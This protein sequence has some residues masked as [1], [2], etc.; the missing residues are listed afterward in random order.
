MAAVRKTVTIVFSDVVGSTPLG[1]RLDPESLRELTT[2]YYRQMA[3]VLQRHGGRVSKFIGDAAMAVFGVPRTHEDDALRAVRAASELAPAL[4]E[5]NHELEAAWGMRLLLRTGVNT[6][7]VVVGD[8]L[9]GQDVT[10]G[11][12]VNLAARLEQAA[13]PGQVV[14][15]ES[16]YRLVRDAVEVEPLPPL[17][18]KGKAEPVSAWTLLAVHP[19][20]PGHARRADAPMVGREAELAR[21]TRAFERSVAGR[22]CCLFTLLGTAGVGKSRLAAEFLASVEGRATVLRGCCLS[23][24][25]GITFWPLAEVLRQAARIAPGDSPAA[26]QAKLAALVGGEERAERIAGLLGRVLGLAGEAG[27]LEETFWAVRRLLEVGAA[28]RPLVVLLDDLHW[29][30]PTMLDLVEH[31][32]GLSRDRPVVLLC[33]GRPELVEQRPGWGG[34][35]ADAELL[36]LEP[37]REEDGLLLL[38]GLL[39]PSE[40]DEAARRRVVRSADGNPLFVEELVLMLV[41]EGHLRREHDRWVPA[42]DLSVLKVPLAVSGVILA[43]L[44]RLERMERAVVDRAAVVGREFT[45]TQVTELAP[46]PPREE[47]GARLE[48]LA[49]KALVRPEP[50]AAAATFGFRHQLLRDVAYEATSKRLRAEL[51]ERLAVWLEAAASDRLPEIQEVLGYHLEQAYRCLAALGAPGERGRLLAGRAG[52]HLGAAGRRAVA[53]EDMPAAVRLLERAA[54]LLPAEDPERLALL[55]DLAEALGAT[56]ELARAEALL[57]EGLELARAAQDERLVA[58][59]GLQRWRWRLFTGP[60]APAETVRR[61]AE[62]RAAVLERLGDQRGLAQAWQLV[63]FV[64]AFQ[65]RFEDELAALVRGLRHAKRAGDRRLQA[66]LAGMVSVALLYG[67]TPLDRAAARAERVLRD[68]REGGDLLGEAD[69]LFDLG[70]LA[71]RRGDAVAAR[72]RLAESA[73]TYQQ[74]GLARAQARIVMEAGANELLADDP[75]AAEVQLRRAY[76]AFERMGDS[77]SCST[78]AAWLAEAAWRGGR[79]D[80]AEEG[81][82]LSERLAALSDVF[83]QV[84]WRG[85]RAKAL[86]RG[87]HQADGERLAAEAVRLADATDNLELRAGALLDLATVLGPVRP[88]EAAGAAAEALRL[89]ERK[90]IVPLATRARRQLEGLPAPAPPAG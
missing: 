86:A 39:G 38:E 53:R 73:A 60:D 80:E 47:V 2:R 72:A 15:G 28:R 23:Y 35:A 22:T 30:E 88:A 29:A 83:T 4:A 13:A 66:S 82:A 45:A 62:R 64:D 46:P 6:G 58:H 78:V 77:G 63:A 71:A 24:G 33:L 8:D 90:G 76:R 75:A 9:Y 65:N 49:R 44:D 20:A 81:S 34:A 48:A 31:V 79:D 16:T 68:A 36:S 51:H 19:G 52:A 59:L 84:V 17:A 56:G 69:A 41:D 54:A 32:A 3:G 43:R 57:A 21:L 55:P 74:L 7:E 42:G 40:L 61:E 5:L 18:V 12:A 14:L 37:L 26:A 67:P 27:Q 85:V 11:D 25:D 70:Q 50:A 89:C 10:V 87:G 1:E